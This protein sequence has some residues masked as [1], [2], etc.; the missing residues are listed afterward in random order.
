ML[1]KLVA[2]AIVNMFV[3]SISAMLPEVPEFRSEEIGLVNHNPAHIM[4][5]VIYDM[6]KAPYFQ[7]ETQDPSKTGLTA[8]EAMDGSIFAQ[9]GNQRVKDP[10]TAAEIFAKLKAAYDASQETRNIRKHRKTSDHPGYY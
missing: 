3:L 8:G 4:N 6:Y 9:I 7:F 2:I 1:K 5:G 10:Q